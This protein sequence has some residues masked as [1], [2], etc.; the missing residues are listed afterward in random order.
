MPFDGEIIRRGFLGLEDMLLDM[1]EF[2]FEGGA[3]WM[4]GKEGNFKGQR[5]LIGAVR[6]VR[7]QTGIRCDEME[8]YLARAI[9]I[10]SN[11]SRLTDSRAITNFNDV[12]GRTFADIVAIIREARELAQVDE[13]VRRMAYPKPTTQTS[14]DVAAIA[15]WLNP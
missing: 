7:E 11:N 9:A 4:Q 14:V 5:C 3:K 15:A 2:S 10:R 8:R 12:R 1:V 13:Y 6:F